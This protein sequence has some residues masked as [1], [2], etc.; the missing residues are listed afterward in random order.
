MAASSFTA[1]IAAEFATYMRALQEQGRSAPIVVDEDAD[2]VVTLES[3]NLLCVTF[4]AGQISAAELAFTADVMQFAER[5]KYATPGL[6]DIVAEF[7]DPEVNG[8]F[9]VSRA[10]ELARGTMS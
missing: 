2:V 8:E 9:T 7:T 4:V 1:S 3:I 10:Q 5:I 6:S